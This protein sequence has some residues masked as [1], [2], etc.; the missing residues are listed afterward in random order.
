MTNETSKTDAEGN[1]PAPRPPS[2][3][4]PDAR[5]WLPQSEP[6]PRP[7]ERKIQTR[8]DARGF[9]QR[10]PLDPGIGDRVGDLP[11]VR[12]E[13]VGPGSAARPGTRL[14]R[15]EAL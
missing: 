2:P 9:H 4:V 11:Y 3:E 12:R 14:T 7:L 1:D 6:L 13:L 10:D 8:T 5:T 15:T